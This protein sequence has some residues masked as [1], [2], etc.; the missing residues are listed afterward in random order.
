MKYEMA[1]Y[2]KD[3]A[4]WHKV[5]STTG[6]TTPDTLEAFTSMM[7]FKKTANGDFWKQEAYDQAI[8]ITIIEE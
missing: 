3:A 4:M 6:E 2:L 5:D 1:H 8:K 7:G